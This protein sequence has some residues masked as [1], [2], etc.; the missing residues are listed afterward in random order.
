[1][2]NGFYR[3]LPGGDQSNYFVDLALGEIPGQS[4]FSQQC[5]RSGIGQSFSDIWGGNVDEMVYPTSAENWQI[6]STSTDDTASGVG[7]RDVLVT[8]LDADLNVQQTVVTLNG[9]TPV[10]LANTHLRPRQALVLSA[11]S[12]EFNQGNIIVESQATGDQRNVIN[13]G[14]G[15][16]YDTHFTIPS[17]K[18]GI[19]VNS[20]SLIP[21][22]A[23]GS[24][25]TL[26]RDG[27]ASNPAWA[28]S[29]P[30]PIYQ[31]I[32]TFDIKA[33]APL[34]PGFDIKAQA[35]ADTGLSS[36][37]VIYE[38]VIADQA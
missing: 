32:V 22:D 26:I 20:F 35:I 38:L 12:A 21:K 25:R 1:V 30:I 4:S 10:T 36:A 3:H 8:S 29:G 27:T 31:N 17:G 13:A 6:R 5:F 19:F 2:T 18:V 34:G 16:S 23:S 28:A 37:L 33:A 24:I 14:F 11:G 15:L 7:A 9:S